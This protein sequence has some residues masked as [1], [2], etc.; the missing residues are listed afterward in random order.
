[1]TEQSKGRK[2]KNEWMEEKSEKQNNGMNESG[3]NE[4]MNG[5]KEKR[6]GK[7]WREGKREKPS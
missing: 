1:M 7:E 2:N 5:E 6:T 4:W 3:R